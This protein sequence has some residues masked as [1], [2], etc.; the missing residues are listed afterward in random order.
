MI[1]N[2]KKSCHDYTYITNMIITNTKLSASAK[3]LLIHMLSFNPEE[4]YDNLQ[5][6][7]T[8][9]FSM[10]KLKRTLKELKEMGIVKPLRLLH[11][12]W[13]LMVDYEKIENMHN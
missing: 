1:I 7:V 2:K 12:K 13:D 3:I 9:K 6:C 8:M 4:N 11:N 10:Q 5:L